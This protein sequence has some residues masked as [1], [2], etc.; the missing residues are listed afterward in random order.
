MD[1]P[2]DEDIE[3]VRY[4]PNCQANAD[5]PICVHC[6]LDELFQVNYLL[7]RYWLY[8]AKMMMILGKF[9]TEESYDR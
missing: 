6:E 3:R 7:T 2:R 1:K 8:E 5:G 9:T 4:C